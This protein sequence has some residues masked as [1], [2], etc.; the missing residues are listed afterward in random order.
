MRRI[1]LSTFIVCLLV[2]SLFISLTSI[3]A[4]QAAPPQAS[5]QAQQVRID[6]A[7]FGA[8]EAR[9]M[10]PATTSGR[11]ASIAGVDSSPNI[12]YVGASSGG[13]WKSIN[14]GTTFKPIFDK[15]TQSIGAIAVD[16]SHP[17]T[18]W[19]GTGEPWVRN[20]TSIG[21]G[22]Y[23]ST[24][25][26]ETWERMG[27]ENTERI[28]KIVVDPKNSDT[29]Y[30]AAMGHLWNDNEERG[31]YKTTDGGR[32][33]ERILDVDQ[34]T[35]ACDVAVDPQETG[36]V[37]A[38][39][40]EFRRQPW[41]FTSG[42]PG[43]GL[44]RST[45]GGKKWEKTSVGLPEG[46]IGRTAIAVARSRPNVVY[47][48]VEG[49]KT[50]MYRSDDM[51]RTWTETS[52][53]TAIGSR[54]FY[55]S[56]LAVDPRD[57]NRVYKP[58]FSLLV[59][60]D[61]GRTFSDRGGPTHSDE[62]AIWIDPTNPATI[63][64]GT[65]GGVYKSTDY[66]NTWSFIRSLPVSQFYH[67]SFDM[68][69]PYNVYGG[70]QDNGSWMAPT[71]SPN[72]IELRDWR[73]VGFG[74]GFYV[75]AD[76]TDNNLVYSEY[77]GGHLLRFNKKTGELKFIAPTRRADEPK[78]RFNWNTP[79]ALSPND[80]HTFYVGAQL[81]IRS[82]DQGE[83]W[84]RISPDLTTNDP[85]KQ[86][87]EESGGLTL[88]NSS[89]ENHCTIYT[90]SESPR[91]A[92]VVWV[93][94]DDGNVQ[95]TEDGG[96]HWANV[97]ANI[98]GL[99]KNTWVSTIEASHFDRNTAYATFDGHQTGDMKTYVYKTTDLGKT[100]TPIATDAIKGY[101][102][103][104]REDLI[105][106]NLLFVGTEFGLFLT[107][108]GGQQWAQFT[109]K[110]PNVA[111]RDI[112]I[113]PR[114]NDMVI[115]THGR[116]IYIVDDITPL[117][118]ITP[119]IL[120]SKFAVLET[121][122]SEI[123][124]GV[125]E[126]NFAGNDEFV[127]SNLPE[128][129]YITYYLRERH[130]FGDFKIQIYD[131]QNNLITTLPA[132]KRRGINRVEWPMRLKPPKVPVG[133]SIEGGSIFGPVVPEGTYTAKFIKGND[134]YTTQ[135][136]L[137]GNPSSPHSAE[138]RQFQQQTVM[139]LYKMLERLAF[140]A[141]QVRDVREEARERAQK[142]GNAQDAVAK[143]LEAFATKLDDLYKTLVA[144]REGQITGEIRL[145]EEIGELYGQIN[146]YGGRPTQSQVERVG[147]LNTEVDRA[148]QSL[149]S[150]LSA[151]LDAI[152]AKLKLKRLDPIKRLTREEYDARESR[153]LVS[154]D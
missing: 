97:T 139:K 14:S 30:V 49:K 42:G 126:Q 78:Y 101:A 10:G 130:V 16:Q 31:I 102:H 121:R 56:I 154:L 11:I 103:V 108:D 55:F 147:G 53:A 137:V 17:D 92:K 79:V 83:S 134:T 1:P 46:N 144:T 107:V 27:L 99:P 98:T 143:S 118:K 148:N 33:W 4:Q 57:Y 90:I 35:G 45:D 21:T 51:G 28:A 127:G 96:G 85:N 50:A 67:A 43:S 122:P 124:L 77:Q 125:I 110:L 82:R 111:V 73:N 47:A 26:G 25:G 63:Y 140:V 84:E 136:R 69:H 151:D 150:I 64:M 80:P 75:F 2:S 44:Y 116:G 13:V 153:S 62:H 145:R 142:L 12:I 9:A 60:N 29:V 71:Y 76:P 70:L 8:I 41:T 104:I 65:D 52:K 19:V 59:S 36:T 3:H 123:R 72:G 22:I 138:E 7:T 61:G 117:R 88:D 119:Q 40:W 38:G 135:V 141:A 94:T 112:A 131:A 58:G 132:G 32:T 6:S 133:Q 152:N 23:K 129:A 95:I 146:G 54:P 113:H 39:M 109:G 24:D 74:D 87:Q 100:W 81:L 120:E 128:V 37:Y 89:A 93:G 48:T 91:D 114:E 115:A 15:Y 34:R 149:E 20:S 5:Q 18:V 68:E 66:A 106:P 105:N 86:K